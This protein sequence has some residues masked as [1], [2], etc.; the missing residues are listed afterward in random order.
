MSGPIRIDSSAVRWR[1]VDGEIVA[2]DLRNSRY[3]AANP[4]ATALWPLLDRG[5]TLHELSVAL[6][7][8]WSLPEEIARRDAERLVAWLREAGLL[9]DTS[10]THKP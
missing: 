9:L 2:V 7:D 1:E 5:T 8:R 10:D 6:S 3:M 4:S